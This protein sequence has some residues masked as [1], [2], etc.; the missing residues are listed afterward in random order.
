MSSKKTILIIEDEKPIIK[1]L[2]NKLKLEGFEILQAK[3]GKEGLEIA[4]EKHP[5]LILSDLIMPKM[6]GMTAIESIR[7]DKWGKKVPIIIL[8][9]LN[10][11]KE[12][13]R[14]T[15]A[16]V[17]DYLIKSDWTMADLVKKIKSKLNIK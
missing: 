3:D 4:L 14:A 6:D 16:D 17:H 5:N 1:A 7:Q 9:N 2:S 10:D 15:E 12:N 11:I 13:T 8:T